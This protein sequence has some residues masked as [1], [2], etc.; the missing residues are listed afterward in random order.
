MKAKSGIFFDQAWATCQ[1]VKSINVG[2]VDSLIWPLIDVPDEEDVISYASWNCL[3]TSL[4]N[5]HIIEEKTV[6][7]SR[8]SANFLKNAQDLERAEQ[9]LQR[10]CTKTTQSLLNKGRTIMSNIYDIVQM[11]LV[12][13]YANCLNTR[14]LKK[15]E[16]PSKRMQKQAKFFA[17]YIAFSAWNP[18][19][20]P[21]WSNSRRFFKKNGESFMRR[22]RTL[23]CQNSLRNSNTFYLPFWYWKLSLEPISELQNKKVPHKSQEFYCLTFFFISVFFFT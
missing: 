8:D 17:D 7:C 16:M 6:R 12:V 11:H 5:I 13:D 14:Q 4:V 21:N 23:S 18:S 10:K 15:L 19:H 1:A 22:F 20:G 9:H 2:G 3:G